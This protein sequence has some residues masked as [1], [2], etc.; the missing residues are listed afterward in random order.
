MLHKQN[1]MKLTLNLNRDIIEFD[2]FPS[3]EVNLSSIPS[4]EARLSLY[5]VDA[6]NNQVKDCGLHNVSWPESQSIYK[7][8]Q[9]VFV[10]QSSHKKQS[11]RICGDLW[12]NKLVATGYSNSFV[13]SHKR[14]KPVESFEPSTLL[15]HVPGIG[16][17]YARR[18]ES[19]QLRTLQDLAQTT[20]TSKEIHAAC[21]AHSDQHVFD[22]IVHKILSEHQVDHTDAKLIV[23]KIQE[24]FFL[25]FSNQVH[26]NHFTLSPQRIHQLKVMA[27]QVCKGTSVSRKRIRC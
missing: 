21:F 3:F 23:D 17:G 9:D 22:M 24:R 1:N 27:D 19:I 10:F 8:K 18:L 11:F 12:Y 5:I 26:T 20:M 4:L 15:L 25:T 2:S 13:V 16:V 6:D 7:V 14:S